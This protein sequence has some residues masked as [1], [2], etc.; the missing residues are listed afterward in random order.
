[1]GSGTVC[2]VKGARNRKGEGEHADLS[3][4]VLG[5]W[6][7][8]GSPAKDA[9]PGA[10]LFYVRHRRR[11]IATDGQAG[12]TVEFRPEGRRVGR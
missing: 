12:V 6:R 10:F 4:Q 5:M 7:R 1:M 11:H 9:R 3:I 2:A 8:G